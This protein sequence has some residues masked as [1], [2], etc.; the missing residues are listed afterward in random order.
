MSIS[1][2]FADMKVTI[3][4]KRDLDC[5]MKDD[6]FLTEDQLDGC[7]ERFLHV[8][9]DN[10]DKDDINKLILKIAKRHVK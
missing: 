2:E 3:I 1:S 9:D 7:K 6:E 5:I 10:D 4:D 8:D